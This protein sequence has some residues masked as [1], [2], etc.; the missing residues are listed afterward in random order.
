V[1]TSGREAPELLDALTKAGGLTFGVRKLTP[2]GLRQMAAD[3]GRLGEP[4]RGELV[5]RRKDQLCLKC[6]AV[7]GA[8]GQVGPDLSSVGASAQVDYL[9]ESLLEPN[10]AIKENYHSLLVTTAAGRQFTGIKVRQ[11]KAELVL[12][13]AEDKEVAVPLK[14]IEEQSQGRSLMPDGLTDTLTRGELLDLVRFLSELG[15]VGPYSVGPARVV[16][17]WEALEATPG[18]LK[19]VQRGGPEAALGN[20]PAL[21]WS[22]A[23]STVAGL[24]PP[25]DVPRL[26]VGQRAVGLLRCQLDASTAGPV[27]LRFNSAQ[28]VSLWLDRKAVVAQDVTELT[29]TAGVHALTV[30]LDL[31]SRREPLRC[32]LDDRPGSP[33]RVRV[34]GGK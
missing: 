17:R 9:I 12:R 6:H 30:A 7:G 14:D 27:L 23:Y 31:G 21:V 11:T 18:A 25:A 10:K 22:P 16:R 4:A 33:A 1:R 26:K 34:V 19:L 28:G 24:L 15:K 2:E 13:T 29:V 5:F 8:G 32:E 20:N 3:V